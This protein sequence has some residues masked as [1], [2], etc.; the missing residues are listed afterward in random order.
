[1]VFHV[2]PVTFFEPVTCTDKINSFQYIR[3]A[4]GVSPEMMMHIVHS[5]T[6]VSVHNKRGTILTTESER[7]SAK[8]LCP[9]SQRWLNVFGT[10]PET[11]CHTC[12]RQRVYTWQGMMVMSRSSSSLFPALTI[13]LALSLSLTLM[14]RVCLQICMCTFICVNKVFLC[15]NNTAMFVSAAAVASVTPDQR[16]LYIKYYKSKGSFYNFHSSCLVCSFISIQSSDYITATI[17][18]ACLWAPCSIP[19]LPFCIL[20]TVHLLSAPQLLL[21][22]YKECK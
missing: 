15:M 18:S 9:A 8:Y 5:L 11:H 12:F 4:D 10:H 20:L 16:P 1:M 6:K 14:C 13:L 17:V 22:V 21:R 19:E 3:V 2:P 7:R